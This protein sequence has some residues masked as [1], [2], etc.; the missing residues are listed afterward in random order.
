MLRILL[1]AF[2][3]ACPAA[4]AR[5][6]QPMIDYTISFP[7]ARADAA[8]MINSFENFTHFSSDFGWMGPGEGR[9]DAKDGIIRVKPAG[10]WTGA[11]HS[12]AG[13]ATQ[14]NRV[15]DP[16]DLVGLGD[17]AAKK[18]GIRALAV[19]AAGRGTLRLELADVQR[20]VVWQTAITLDGSDIRNNT[21]PGP[22]RQGRV[23]S[24]SPPG[25]RACP[26]LVIPPTARKSRAHAGFTRTTC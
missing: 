8:P 9:I 12:L 7:G 21:G 22:L 10:E 15:F 6:W 11:W 20:K 3:L 24:D 4:G 18:C 13:L 2:A 16:A 26:A 25:K 17:D 5:V 23:F 14:K 19:N 1:S